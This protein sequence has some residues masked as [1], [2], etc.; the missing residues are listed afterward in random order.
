MSGFVPHSPAAFGAR[1]PAAAGAWGND[2]RSI[3]GEDRN[4]LSTL[5][6]RCE[7]ARDRRDADEGAKVPGYPPLERRSKII[8]SFGNVVDEISF[9]IDAYENRTTGSKSR[10]TSVATTAMETISTQDS[11]ASGMLVAFA[12]DVERLELMIVGEEGVKSGYAAMN[13]SFGG[14]GISL[15]SDKLSDVSVLTD[16]R[17]FEEQGDVEPL[18]E[19]SVISDQVFPSTDYLLFRMPEAVLLQLEVTSLSCSTFTRHGGSRN[20]NLTIGQVSAKGDNEVSLLAI[21]ADASD[22]PLSDIEVRADSLEISPRPS[23]K[24]NVPLEALS[25]S[26]IVKCD[27]LIVRVSIDPSTIS[28]LLAF[29]AQGSVLFPRQLLP[30]SPREEVRRYVLQQN[31]ASFSALNCSIRIHGCEIS[32]PLQ[33]DKTGDNKNDSQFDSPNPGAVLRCEIIEIYSGIAIEEL[34]ASMEDWHRDD[35][36]GDVETSLP[37]SMLGLSMVQTRQLGMLDVPELMVMNKGLVTSH[38]VSA[39]FLFFRLKFSLLNS[40]AAQPCQTC[41]W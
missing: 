8:G 37:S 24:A 16:D 6:A 2:D 13:E 25:L 35:G 38:W 4:Y 39:Q 7:V 36:D 26:V 1:G 23:A 9:G 30:R 28:K 11:V 31:E 17:L 20:L 19:E 27:A 22:V 40:F 33:E 41:R 21:G 5:S 10:P 32:L 14:G 34:S 3:D 18:A 12:V 29:S 15:N